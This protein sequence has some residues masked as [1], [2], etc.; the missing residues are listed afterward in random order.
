MNRLLADALDGRKFIDALTEA[1][2]SGVVVSD[3]QRRYWAV[4]GQQV[5]GENRQQ[6]R[7]RERNERR[8]K[9]TRRGNAR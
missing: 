4:F 2:A 3:E 5:P 9:S 6:R 8:A 1:D 7:A